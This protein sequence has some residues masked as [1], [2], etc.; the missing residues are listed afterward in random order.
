[1]FSLHKPLL[2]LTLLAM[3]ITVS[4]V[5]RLSARRSD[6]QNEASDGGIVIVHLAL[7][8]RAHSRANKQSVQGSVGHG[9]ISLLQVRHRIEG[10]SG[11]R[12]G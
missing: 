10:M 4:Q 12:T 3:G 2:L 9:H 8:L 1:M 7:T 6:F 11:Y 5:K